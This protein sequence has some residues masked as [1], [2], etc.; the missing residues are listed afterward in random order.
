MSRW[1]SAEP[2]TPRATTRE[3]QTWVTAVVSASSFYGGG[4]PEGSDR[5]GSSDGGGLIGQ[6]PGGM[7]RWNIA[8]RR[9]AA[10]VG[11]PHLGVQHRRSAAVFRFFRAEGVVWRGLGPKGL[12]GWGLGKWTCLDP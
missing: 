3:H 8:C 7:D 6:A 2:C 11:V 5:H 4:L 1:L 9:S 10:S 12:M